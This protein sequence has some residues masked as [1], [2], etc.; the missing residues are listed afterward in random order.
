MKQKKEYWIS[1]LVNKNPAP[2]VFSSERMVVIDY[3]DRNQPQWIIIQLR[4]VIEAGNFSKFS[5]ELNLL[6]PAYIL[7]TPTQKDKKNVFVFLHDIDC[8]SVCLPIKL[9]IHETRENLQR[10]L[11]VLDSVESFTKKWSKNN[12][13]IVNSD[14]V[15][16]LQ[17]G[18]LKRKRA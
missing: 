12:I 10:L 9:L 13:Q 18:K 7:V 5:D 8:C 14:L 3:L 11:N 4:N 15:F 16:D 2:V 6:I 17:K 1:C